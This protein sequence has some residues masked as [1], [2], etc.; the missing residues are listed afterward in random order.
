MKC[1]YTDTGLSAVD[2]RLQQRNMKILCIQRIHFK[3]LLN[4]NTAPHNT[5]NSIAVQCAVNVS[6][7]RAQRALWD[8]LWPSA[9]HCP[10]PQQP[11]PW[12]H[13]WRQSHDTVWAETVHEKLHRQCHLV[14]TDDSSRRDGR[15][16]RNSTRE[17]RVTTEV[18]ATVYSAQWR[19]KWQI[20]ATEAG[21]GSRKLVT[22]SCGYFFVLQ[23]HFDARSPVESRSWKWTD[24][25]SCKSC[26]G[27]YNGGL[28]P[29][30]SRH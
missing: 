22:K 5:V 21:G 8:R 14:S 17:V 25:D 23:Q 9:C 10:L 16:A 29:E 13:H 4:W 20:N 3:I 30:N 27:H 18:T 12:L 28:C 6:A 19:Y 11:R 26:G 2:F 24:G 1:S 15:G 7:A